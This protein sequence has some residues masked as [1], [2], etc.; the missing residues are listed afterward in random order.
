MLDVF[1][2][3]FVAHRLQLCA[4]DGLIALAQDSQILRNRGSRRYMVAGDHD[5]LDA[6]VV[7]L[8]DGGLY[9]LSG[10]IDH[11]D[12]AD[13]GQILFQFIG[14]VFTGLFIDHLATDCQN[15][16]RSL[17]HL[18]VGVGRRLNIAGGAAAEQNI[19]SALD[20]NNDL[21]V[22]FYDG[23]HQLTVRVKRNL[24]D[25]G[26]RA[27]QFCAVNIVAHG[28]GYDSGFSRVAQMFLRAILL[29]AHNTVCAQSTKAQQR[30]GLFRKI[31]VQRNNALLFGIRLHQSHTVLGQGTCFIGAND[32]GAAQGFNRGQLTDNRVF[33]NHALHAES[34]H[35]GNDRRQAFGDCCNGQRNSRHKHFKNSGYRIFAVQRAD[36]VNQTDNEYDR[37]DHQ[38]EDTK[39]FTKLCQLLLQRGHA[40]LF[41]VQQSGDLAHFG[42]HTG[43]DD[44]RLRR[45]IRNRAAGM[46]HIKAVAQRSVLFYVVCRCFICGNRF[47]GKSCFIT[48]EAGAADQTAVSGN[49]VTCLQFDHVAGNQMSR[50][51][52]LHL[53]ITE[54]LSIGG[55]HVFQRFQS[56]FRLTLLNDTHHAVE[57]DDQY[58]N[59]RLD[60]LSLVAIH[61]V[62]NTQNN[63]D[64]RRDHQDDNHNIL[65]LIHKTLEES[66]GRLF[67]QLI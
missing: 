3:L 13:E 19:R 47:T 21:T 59:D 37:T 38:S 8:G 6:G 44:K 28:A 48:L 24:A 20:D 25:S 40:L 36:N 41:F 35:D 51:N 58:D 4:G 11:T 23:R 16:Q 53:T 1:G 46:Y 26:C 50:R 17:C 22:G 32:R 27:I 30:K 14:G 39:V 33:L 65:H 5:G 54:H 63:R 52:G 55:R 2:Q 64:E 29:N 60:P 66:T 43:A 56:S 12:Q 31:A 9:F 62:V 49:K 45:T 15:A 18:F 57:H 67:V 7:A 42:F 34:E 10:R 61:C